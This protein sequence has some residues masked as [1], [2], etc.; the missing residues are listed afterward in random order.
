MGDEKGLTKK[1]EEVNFFIYIFWINFFF[2]PTIDQM[3]IF[4]GKFLVKIQFKNTM[5]VGPMLIKL[6]F[7]KLISGLIFCNLS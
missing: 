4:T 1:K 7:Q 5:T 2:M 3:S 6:D